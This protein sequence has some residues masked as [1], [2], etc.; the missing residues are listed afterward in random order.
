M[1]IGHGQFGKVYL[2][3]CRR[4]VDGVT[5]VAVKLV[6]ADASAPDAA[7]FMQVG[8]A[9]VYLVWGMYGGEG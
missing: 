3:E 6:R 7:E 5:N 2:A 4:N 8:V 1:I 9:G